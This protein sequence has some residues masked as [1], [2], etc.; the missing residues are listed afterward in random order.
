MEEHLEATKKELQQLHATEQKDIAEK[1]QKE[2]D[3]LRH[4]FIAVK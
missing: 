1:Y 4:E 3:A 2:I